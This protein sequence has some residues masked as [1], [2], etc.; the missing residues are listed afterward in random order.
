ADNEDHPTA[1]GANSLSEHFN[2]VATDTDG[3]TASGSLDV[4]VVDD[5][6]TAVNDSNGV[7][8]ESQLVLSG[9]VLSN[10]V[11]GADR[12]PSGPVTAG[13]FTGTYGTLVLAADGTYTYTLNTADADFKA[14]H[15]N[16][17][18]TETFAYTITDADGDP[19]TANLVLNIHNNDDG[20]TFNGLDSNGDELTVYEK[21]LPDGSSPNAAALTQSG[22]FTVTAL[23]GLQTLTVGGISVVSGGV[24]AGFPQSI[25]TD[26]GNTLTITGYN[27]ATGVISYSYTLAD[28]EDHPTANG[29]NSLSEHFNVVATD[30]D[31]STASGSLDVNVVDD[32]PTAVN[33][34]NGVASES[35][36]VL[37]GNVLSNDVQGA[38]RVP[39]GPVTAG[40]FTG[41]YGTLVLAADGTYTYTLNTAD[42]DF[43]ALHGNGNGTETFAYTI[44][45]ADGDPSTANLVLNIHNNDD[46]VTLDCLDIPGGELRV[47]EKHLS[48]GTSPNAPAL[49]QSG[50]FIVTA[51]DGLQT[52]T[53]GGIN[54]VTGGV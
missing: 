36:L 42:A 46:G 35:Q 41:T 18:G 34:S 22:S 17:N 28:N 32:L 7:A 53:V 25:T 48:D 19:S 45:D 16:G 37:S 29:A 49:T 23:D 40:T 24:A 3:S 10:D 43:K 5:L 14:L 21:N 8:S 30:T 50:F 47:Y 20:V 31:G 11:Q 26:L 15:G 1:N 44:T 12:V 2:V 33:D 38:D 9:N 13:T 6:P 4:N 52:L 54:V 51:P 27:A 39:S